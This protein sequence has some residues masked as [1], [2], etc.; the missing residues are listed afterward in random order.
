MHSMQGDV[1]ARQSRA[2]IQELNHLA[3]HGD[4]AQLSIVA[5]VTVLKRVGALQCE[6]SALVACQPYFCEGNSIVEELH[7]IHLTLAARARH[8]DLP[9]TGT[10]EP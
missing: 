8:S 1:R 10:F 3:K 4:V 9:D 7:L 2:E 5:C 6:A